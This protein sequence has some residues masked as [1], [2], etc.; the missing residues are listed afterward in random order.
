[1]AR[2]VTSDIQPCSGCEQL[3]WKSMSDSAEQIAGNMEGLEP[4]PDRLCKGIREAGGI[5]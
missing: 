1:M 3:C 2:Y 5:V 4:P